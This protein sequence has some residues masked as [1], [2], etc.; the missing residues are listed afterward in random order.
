[1]KLS[2]V[3]NGN[4]MPDEEVQTATES[5][6][7]EAIG[8]KILHLSEDIPGTLHVETDGYGE[9]DFNLGKR[10]SFIRNGIEIPSMYVT[11]SGNSITGLAASSYKPAYLTC[12][13]PESNNYKFYYLKPGP[14]GIDVTYGRIGARQGEMFGERSIAQPYPN[15]MYWIRY[16]EKLS[17]GYVDQSNIYLAEKV[18]KKR[19]TKPAQVPDGPSADLYNMLLRYARHVVRK[20]LV[21]EHVTKAQAKEARRIYTE[22]CKKVQVKA[23]NR[24]LMKLIVL[25]PRRIGGKEEGGVQSLLARSKDDFA[26]IILREESLL[27][28][29]ETVAGSAENKEGS[30]PDGSFDQF[31]IDVF[32]ATPE[33]TEKVVSKLSDQLKPL[34]KTVYRI[35]PHEQKAR[36]D[37]YLK[38]HKI[39]KVKELWHGSKNENWLSIIV[40]SLQLN[41]NAQITGKMFGQGIY[42]APSSM[43]SWGYTSFRGTHW[44]GGT[45]NTAFMG[46]YATAYGKPYHPDST[47]YGCWIDGSFIE[48]KHCN[49]LH[50]QASK[51][52]L[53]NDE[54]VYYDEAAVCLNYIVEFSAS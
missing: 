51:T 29:M 38:S 10:G 20:T 39:K 37:D 19:G 40:N 8:K 28:A 43:K 13:N 23:F 4:K 44:A 42:F 50:A 15:H 6:V 47:V 32:I 2:Y 25:S 34:V 46:V 27:V 21:N 7:Y 52:N 54:I 1:M 36:F 48:S 5:A 16:Y 33:Q 3:Y 17:K 11:E 30:A 12:I 26:G 53:Y 9:A 22:L 41:P 24:W 35:V 18:S 14:T 45:Q 49:C 31:G